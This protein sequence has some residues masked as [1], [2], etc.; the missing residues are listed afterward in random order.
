MAGRP[1]DY[2][3]DLATDFCSLLASGED[4]EAI[5][6]KEGMPVPATIFRWR[7]VHPEFKE[8]Y[9][10]ARETKV[11]IRADRIQRRSEDALN[12]VLDCNDP[13]LAAAIVQAVKLEVETAKFNAVKL[14]PKVY[15]D[16]IKH[17]GADGEGPVQFVITRAGSKEK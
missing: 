17:T 10:L 5:C 3:E 4:V 15:G 2:T 7:H 8:M 6:A 13:K 14:L 1:T 9:A 11:E 12:L 16:S